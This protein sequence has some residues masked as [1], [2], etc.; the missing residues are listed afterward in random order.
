MYVRSQQRNHHTRDEL[1]NEPAD[2]HYRDTE[3]NVTEDLQGYLPGIF[4]R[5]AAVLQ[6]ECIVTRR[7]NG[8]SPMHRVTRYVR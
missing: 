7:F 1:A 4:K 3:Q 2:A 5:V 6:V 8:P